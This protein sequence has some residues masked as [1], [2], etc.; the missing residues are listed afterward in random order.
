MAMSNFFFNK[1]PKS[2]YFY[3][4][5]KCGFSRNLGSAERDETKRK[6]QDHPEDDTNDRLEGTL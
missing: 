6:T 2:R 1:L 5:K 4:M 3:I